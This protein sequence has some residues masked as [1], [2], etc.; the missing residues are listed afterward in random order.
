[1]SRS[2]ILGNLRKF[3]ETSFGNFGDE[4]FFEV[5]LS[6]SDISAAFY[7]FKRRIGILYLS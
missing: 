1:M 3:M 2:I 4:V 5:T 7:P 6:I